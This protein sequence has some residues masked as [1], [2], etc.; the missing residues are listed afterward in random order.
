MDRCCNHSPSRMD[1]SIYN[2]N[3]MDHNNNRKLVMFYEMIFQQT[4]TVKRWLKQAKATVA[5]VHRAVSGLTIQKHTTL[6]NYIS[7][8]I[9]KL[10]PRKPLSPIPGRLSQILRS[11][12]ADFDSSRINNPGSYFSVTSSVTPSVTSSVT[13]SDGQ[14]NNRWLW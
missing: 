14:S 8:Q 1:T 10:S 5:Q 12:V 6:V 4:K 7:K 13:S 9:S 11:K 3:N 2:G